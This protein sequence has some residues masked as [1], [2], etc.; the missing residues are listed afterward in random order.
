MKILVAFEKTSYRLVPMTREG[1]MA[2]LETSQGQS[3]NTPDLG[4]GLDPSLQLS[5]SLPRFC[6]GRLTY[7]TWTN[8]VAL[9]APSD[10]LTYHPLILRRYQSS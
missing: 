10:V 2:M 9:I 5:I 6:G 1:P 3:K 8:A 4:D 7:Y